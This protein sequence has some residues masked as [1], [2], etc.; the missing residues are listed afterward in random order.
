MR[1]AFPVLLQFP[2]G[3]DMQINMTGFL[4]QKNARTFISELWELLSSAM[5][6]IGG[7]P[8]KFVEEKKQEIRR[9]QVRSLRPFTTGDK[10]SL[11]GRPNCVAECNQQ[12][13]TRRMLLA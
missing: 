6:N 11:P 10:I 7:I 4:N 5:E 1:V 9:K 8:A 12:H 13:S 2:D 3:K